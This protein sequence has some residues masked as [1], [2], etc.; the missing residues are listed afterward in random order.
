MSI[1]EQCH[2][3]QVPR[4]SYDIYIRAYES[5]HDLYLGLKRYFDKYAQRRHQDIRMSPEQKYAE[6]PMPLAA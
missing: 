1:F 4:S 2:L 3:L 5:M 6:I